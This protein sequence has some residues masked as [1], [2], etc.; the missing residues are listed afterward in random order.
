M[1]LHAANQTM[2]P[3]RD[4]L[5]TNGFTGS[6]AEFAVVSGNLLIDVNPDECREL[7]RHNKRA[8]D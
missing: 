6:V 2:L 4:T 5:D 7:D 8:R 1:G 3:Q